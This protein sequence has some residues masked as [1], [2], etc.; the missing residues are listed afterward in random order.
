MKKLMISLVIATSSCFAML[1]PA[2][3]ASHKTETHSSQVQNQKE[4]A[5]AKQVK[6]KQ[7]AA[8]KHKITKQ[9][10]KPEPVKKSTSAQHKNVH[11]KAKNG[12]PKHF[13]AQ[14]KVDQR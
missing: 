13:T 1:S 7:V 11:V 9:H 14:K 10:S 8:S 4:K 6:A 5:N 12:S 2:S 3:A